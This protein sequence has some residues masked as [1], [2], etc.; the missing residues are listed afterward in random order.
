MPA[1]STGVA[2]DEETFSQGGVTV[3][4]NVNT[5]AAAIR[6]P[7][8]PNTDAEPEDLKGFARF[9]RTHS[10]PR[11]QRVTAGGRIV[12]AEPNSP[13]PTFHQA[14]LEQFV[15]KGDK[16]NVVSGQ[17]PAVHPALNI[18]S[19]FKVL[20]I[21]R[22]GTAAIICN[23]KTL[24]HA[25]LTSTGE[26]SWELIKPTSGAYYIPVS[27]GRPSQPQYTEP[28]R[29]LQQFQDGGDVF[30]E[31]N[32]L[33]PQD[34]QTEQLGVS[35]FSQQAVNM[36]HQQSGALEYPEYGN[37]CFEEQSSNAN[38]AQTYAPPSA[39]PFQVAGNLQVRNPET[40][41]P[42]DLNLVT[43]KSED[44]KQQLRALERCAAKNN[45]ELTES[46]V[47]AYAEEK[48]YLINMVDGLRRQKECLEA[49]KQTAIQQM[50][51]F[52][53]HPAYLERPNC[54]TVDQAYQSI[55]FIP[56]THVKHNTIAAQHH[57]EA[58]SGAYTE[59]KSSNE[60]ARTD[61]NS[62]GSSLAVGSSHWA[63]SPRATPFVPSVNTGA[64][65]EGSSKLIV[66]SEEG[67]ESVNIGQERNLTEAHATDAG[68]EDLHRALAIKDTKLQ[69]QRTAAKTIDIS[70]DST[71]KRQVSKSPAT[72]EDGRKRTEAAVI[73][74]MQNEVEEIRDPIRVLQKEPSAAKPWTWSRLP[75]ESQE[76]Y[77]ERISKRHKENSQGRVPKPGPSLKDENAPFQHEAIGTVLKEP[78]NAAANALAA[79]MRRGLQRSSVGIRGGNSSS[80]SFHTMPASIRSGSSN[81]PSFSDNSLSACSADPGFTTLNDTYVGMAASNHNPSSFNNASMGRRGVSF[82]PGRSDYVPVDVACGPSNFGALDGASPSIRG[83]TSLPPRFKEGL[84]EGRHGYPVTSFS[85]NAV[86]GIERGDYGTA[87]FNGATYP[88]AWQPYGA[89]QQFFSTIP[90][91]FVGP[92][93]PPISYSWDR[94]HGS[95]PHSSR[96]GYPHFTL[97]LSGN[98][99]PSY[100][101]FVPHAYRP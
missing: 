15:D 65:N 98:K 56:T 34:L 54:F 61:S 38:L 71:D 57:S 76:L 36:M 96:Y 24:L 101:S 14:F 45:L 68:S 59:R 94:C 46:D 30:S 52:Q 80:V 27:R 60:A 28:H 22:T 37:I 81:F 9:L 43:V 77:E 62:N 95:S 50:I 21:E 78:P 55:P 93:A 97:D 58:A 33:M 90:Q 51:S 87:A 88:F 100:Y 85:N 1:S 19:G 13:P 5:P 44:I 20:K 53:Q 79:S 2:S 7:C 66:A 29:P 4:R 10:S 73:Y 8:Q 47:R 67:D 72:T 32:L 92:S 12:P 91:H 82:N 69:A 75:N 89:N 63:L 39:Y 41:L 64:L 3:S 26:T 84:I 70:A 83:G 42:D 49:A 40:G 23:G 74:K 6:E 35:R 31:I 25:R 16:K 48:R 18:P 11:H 99:A 86:I 17:R